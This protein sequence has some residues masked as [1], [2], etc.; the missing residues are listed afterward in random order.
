[1]THGEVILAWDQDLTQ[2][3]RFQL[4]DLSQF[5]MRIRGRFPILSGAGG[6]AISLLPERATINRV[7]TVRWVEG[8]D[9]TGLY[10]AGVEFVDAAV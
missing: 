1:M 7:L 6:I 9:D 3:L 2:Y 4:V 5:G 10:E 8:P